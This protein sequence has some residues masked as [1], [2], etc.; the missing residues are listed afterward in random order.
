[1]G[2]RLTKMN[3]PTFLPKIF[4][5]QNRPGKLART[6]IRALLIFSFIPLSLMAVAAY[7]RTRDLLQSQ[8][9][10]Q[11]QNLVTTEMTATQNAMKIKQNHLAS[12]DRIV[13]EI[14]TRVWSANTIDGILQTA[15]KE[16][17]RALNLSEATIE[18]NVEEQGAVK[19]E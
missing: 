7:L 14:T 16:I 2:I 6:I 19:D 8:V 17:G 15:V 13:A 1:L 18:L 10:T 4:N 3:T 11:M 9:V 12:V 5:R